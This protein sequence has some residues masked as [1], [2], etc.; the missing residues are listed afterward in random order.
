MV[1][2]SSYGELAA[3]ACRSP[4]QTSEKVKENSLNISATSRAGQPLLS[5]PTELGGRVQ[6]SVDQH[7]KG[8]F[9][10]SAVRDPV[11]KLR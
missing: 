4:A 11:T 6:Y 3:T 9:D 7:R 2:Y 8:K 1:L 10:S 5:V